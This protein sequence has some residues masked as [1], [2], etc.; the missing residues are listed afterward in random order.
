L[1][2]VAGA[3]HGFDAMAPTTSIAREFIASQHSVLRRAFAA[4]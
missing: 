2:V 4:D 3:F 1:A